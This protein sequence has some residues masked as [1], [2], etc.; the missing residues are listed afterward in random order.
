MKKLF[1]FSVVIM[2]IMTLL[3]PMFTVNVSAVGNSTTQSQMLNYTS[4]KIAVGQK[5][6]LK[7]KASQKVSWG[8][9]DKSIVKVNTKGY[10]TGVSLGSTKI[11]AIVNGKKYYCKVEVVVPSIQRPVDELFVMT[12]KGKSITL[13]TNITTGVKWKSLNPYVAD[14]NNSGKVTVKKEGMAEIVA[15]V[16][17]KTSSRYI[18]SIDDFYYSIDWTRH[19]PTYLA[20]HYNCADAYSYLPSDLTAMINIMDYDRTNRDPYTTYAFD[21]IA[22]ANSEL[23]PKSVFEQNTNVYIFQKGDKY[24]NYTIKECETYFASKSD[25]GNL[26]TSE[27]YGLD[28]AYLS[29]HGK[30]TF[31]CYIQC[32]WNSYINDVEYNISPKDVKKILGSKKL[33]IVYENSSFSLTFTP[34]QNKYIKRYLSPGQ[35]AKFSITIGDYYNSRYVRFNDTEPNEGGYIIAD[36][37]KI[38]YIS[39]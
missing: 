14:V 3:V 26:K 8:T 2:L 20:E 30:A 19:I 7:A 29:A 10:I 21:F 32:K 22:L 18:C 17:G 4:I 38:T 27:K 5:V 31:D 24:G 9:Y 6:Q 37:S 34:E 36:V 23:H 12:Q 11:R 13:K 25:Q 35:S 33:P 1:K 16:A 39:R 15:T 28:F